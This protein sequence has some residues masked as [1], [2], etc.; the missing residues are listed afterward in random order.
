MRDAADA[1]LPDSVATFYDMLDTAARRAATTSTSAR[2]SRARCAAPTSSSRRLHEARRRR[3]GRSTCA[4]SSASAPA[5]SRR[6]RRSTASYVGPLDPTR[7][8]RSS[9]TCA[10]GAEPLPDRSSSAPT[11]AT[12]RRRRARTAA[13]VSHEHDALLLQGHRRARAC[14]TLD[15][16][17]RRGGYEALRK[18]LDDGRRPRCSQELEASGLR[19]RGG[20]GFAMGTKVVASCPRATMDKYLVCNAD[21]SEPGTFKDREL[22]QKNP[23]LLIEGIIIAAY[24]AGA[25]T[26]VHLHPRR[27]RAAG[28]HPRG[29]DRR[30]R[31]GAAT[32]ASD[33]LG[34]DHSLS[35]VRAPR[36]RRL[37]L[38]RGDRRCSTRSRASAATRA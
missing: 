22:M 26:R 20:A 4:R 38:R 36:R 29:G 5:T 6:W 13:G 7:R 17:E 10:A 25:N 31:R 8:P 21:E 2:T 15:V 37:H 16:Y 33:I 11:P 28:R 1:R 32:S 24:A 19:G 18:A 9:R 14:N 34:S 23:H 30:G 27:V 3:P 35:L 12:S